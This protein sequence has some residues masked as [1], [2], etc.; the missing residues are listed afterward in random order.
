MGGGVYVVVRSYMETNQILPESQSEMSPG[1]KT[2][3]SPVNCLIPGVFLRSC[4]TQMCVFVYIKVCMC[5]V[6]YV[7]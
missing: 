1:L 6:V 5:C 4:L 2:G 3:R 7:V